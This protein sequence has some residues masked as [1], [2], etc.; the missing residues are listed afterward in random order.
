MNKLLILLLFWPVLGRSQD[1]IRTRLTKPFAP[2]HTVYGG[3]QI[4]LNY[5]LG[6]R[7]QFSPRLSAQ[8]QGGLIAAPFERYTLKLLTGFGLDPKLGG[9]I[10]R[11]FRQGSSLGVGV[12]VHARSPWYGGLFGQYVHLAAGPVSPADGLGVYF[13]QDF[14]GFGL[15]ASPSFVFNLQTNLWVGGLRVG[16]SVR[17]GDS[18]FGLNLEA[19][20]GKILSTQ[21]HFSSNRSLVDGLGITQGLYRTLSDEIDSKLRRSGYL[22][23]VNAWLTYRL[24]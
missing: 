20:V 13:K 17:F 22:P 5:A 24:I 12:N 7:F 2:T 8:V 1:S 15:L 6:Y 23:T 3:L 4:P 14:S 21:N 19:S 18:R 10:D 11:S 16:R 9:L